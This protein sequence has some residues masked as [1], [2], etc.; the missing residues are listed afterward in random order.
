MATVNMVNIMN[1]NCI[2][3]YWKDDFYFCEDKI[4]ATMAEFYHRPHELMFCGTMNFSYTRNTFENTCIGRRICV[5]Y[6]NENKFLEK[7]HGISIHSINKTDTSC[8]PDDIY[9]LCK[10]K[11]KQ[12][13]PV[14]IGLNNLSSV[15]EIKPGEEEVE[16]LPFLVVGINEDRSINI[17]NFHE[18]GIIS[19]ISKETFL[20]SYRWYTSFAVKKDVQD[21][22]I[23]ELLVKVCEIQKLHAPLMNDCYE[24]F[25]NYPNISKNDDI[26]RY[27]STHDS[28]KE[29]LDLSCDIL[30]MDLSAETG[31][32]KSVL[33]V[34]FY[35]DLLVLY[36]SRL[37]F[38]KAL[39]YLNNYFDFTLFDQIIY[40]SM[41]SSS[42]WNYIRMLFA[43][44][45][46]NNRLDMET[47]ICISKIIKQI[48]SYEL[49]INNELIDI[50]KKSRSDIF[51]YSCKS[52]NLKTDRTIDTENFSQKYLVDL[53]NH[54]NHRLFSKTPNEKND[55]QPLTDK[56]YYKGSVPFGAIYHDE[57]ACF[58]YP[59]SNTLG[60]SIICVGQRLEIKKGFYSY[61]TF[62]GSA[63]YNEMVYDYVILN[64]ADGTPERICLG[65]NGWN[66]NKYDIDTS[67]KKII[68]QGDV[69]KRELINTFENVRKARIY[70]K[71]YKISKESEVTSIAFPMN[72][73]LS[74][75]AITFDKRGI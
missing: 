12:G 58:L 4:I 26:L 72:P 31:G 74:I 29:M 34:P 48:A 67:H 13:T 15:W 40:K 30:D 8:S 18:L 64:H 5:T 21:I 41:V 66:D 68:W 11:M 16:V 1:D 7:F 70:S 17:V 73:F 36:R 33:F 63:L 19:T 60:D 62:I 10:E 54:Y 14:A 69:E 53:S 45:Y 43:N 57:N 25:S 75:I 20:Q 39:S 47:K 61:I 27:D 9:D 37:V 46:H 38:T 55:N 42:K 32:R 56:Y 24:I 22:D 23:E 49:E 51:L 71:K 35:F 44:S 59:Q 6:A 2:D 52:K 65:F 28:Y 50:L 3:T